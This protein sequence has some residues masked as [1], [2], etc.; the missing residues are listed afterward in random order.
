M[1]IFSDIV[2]DIGGYLVWRWIGDRM[3]DLQK[4]STGFWMALG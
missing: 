2:C 4:H 3:A 1:D